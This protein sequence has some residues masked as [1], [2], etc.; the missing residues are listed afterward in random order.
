[1]NDY[2]L[3]TQTTDG[4]SNYNRLKQSSVDSVERSLHSKR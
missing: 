3:K 2:Y 4:N 1:M